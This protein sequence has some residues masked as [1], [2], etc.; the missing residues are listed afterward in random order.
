MTP[1][2]NDEEEVLDE[3]STTTPTITST[4]LGESGWTRLNYKGPYF[5]DNRRLLKHRAKNCECYICIRELKKLPPME[6]HEEYVAGIKSKLEEREIKRAKR[7]AKKDVK[8]GK[9][10]TIKKFFRASADY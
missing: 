4:V 9:Q 6:T 2:T 3:T 5:H 7:K 1:P 8:D 10:A